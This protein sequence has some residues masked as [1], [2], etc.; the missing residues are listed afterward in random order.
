MVVRH[1]ENHIRQAFRLTTL[2]LRRGGPA[3]E[4]AK[5][6]KEEVAELSHVEFRVQVAQRNVGNGTKV[7]GIWK[8]KTFCHGYFSPSALI[9]SAFWSAPGGGRR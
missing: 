4:D 7:T 8:K 1:D 9:R 5:D 3:Y 2:R 6:T